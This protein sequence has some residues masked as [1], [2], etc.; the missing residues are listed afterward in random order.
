MN[1]NTFCQKRITWKYKSNN[2][3]E[4][5]YFETAASKSKNKHNYIIELGYIYD[6]IQV[7][8]TFDNTILVNEIVNHH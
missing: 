8:F 7:N 5:E 6:C 1:N 4:L 2:S 3:F